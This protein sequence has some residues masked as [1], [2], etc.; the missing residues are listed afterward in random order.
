MSLRDFIRVTTKDFQDAN[1]KKATLSEQPLPNPAD[2]SVAKA[3]NAS[4][5]SEREE[6]AEKEEQL[7]GRKKTKRWERAKAR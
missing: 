3:G 7:M 4:E 1:A 2:S 5:E 6:K